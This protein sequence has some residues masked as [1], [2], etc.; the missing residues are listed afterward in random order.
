MTEM[1]VTWKGLVPPL[2][3]NGLRLYIHIIAGKKPEF[4]LGV[5]LRLL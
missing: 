5:M 1:K 3:C 4:W 2:C